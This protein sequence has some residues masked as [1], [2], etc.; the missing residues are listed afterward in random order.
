MLGPAQHMAQQSEEQHRHAASNK[1]LDTGGVTLW[2]D[3]ACLL[4]A[5]LIS[6]VGPGL[7]RSELHHKPVAEGGDAKRCS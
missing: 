4:A 5:A 6:P 3:S 1:H 7:A 2:Q